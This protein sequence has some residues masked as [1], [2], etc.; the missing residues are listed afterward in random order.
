[1]KFKNLLILLVLAMFVIAGC[2]SAEESKDS[3]AASTTGSGT[4]TT[5]STTQTTSIN[6]R[7]DFSSKTSSIMF[8]A[9]GTASDVASITVYAYRVSDNVLI[10][11]TQLA[12]EGGIWEGTLTDLPYGEALNLTASAYDASNTEIFSGNLNKTLADG[13]NNDVTFELAS[14]DDGVDTNGP[15]VVSATLPMTVLIDSSDHV[16]SFQIAYPSDVNYS[17]TAV[18]G[19]LAMNMGDTP[20]SVLSGIHNPAG[21]LVMYYYA[22]ASPLIATL[23]VTV[24]DVNGSDLI[25]AN[26]TINVVNTDPDTW[27]DSGI[28]VVFGPAITG[29]EVTRSETTLKLELTTD[30]STGL[31]YSWTGT[32]S[33]ASLNETGNP[34]F[35]ANFDDTQA[36]EI[37]VTVTDANDIEAFM[38]RTIEAGEYPY[39]VNNYIA[40]MPGIYIHDEVTDLLWMDNDNK[41]RRNWT[42]ANDYCANL[43]LIDFSV[44]RLPT[45]TELSNMYD[46]RADFSNYYTLQYW[47]ADEDPAFSTKAFVIDYADNSQSSQ[48]KS[49]DKIV[50]CVKD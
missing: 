14:V 10:Q 7:I 30:P 15:K 44:W 35:L 49:R 4:D 9:L 36:G 20:V 45:V 38:T 46:R 24:Q 3:V 17:V 40:D 33:F 43:T 22:P 13:Q 11:S 2:D 6:V 21:D 23:T 34:I 5:D 37:H 29:M 47:T 19:K 28:D 31:T 42:E 39:T 8:N 25:G 27:T 12:N 18:G 16:I 26:F 1:M 41:I 48:K 50:R 32:G